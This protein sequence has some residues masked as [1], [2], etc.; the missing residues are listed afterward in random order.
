[1]DPIVLRFCILT[2][3]NQMAVR[4]LFISKASVHMLDMRD[5]MKPYWF[6]N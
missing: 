6:M 3:E 1:M 4:I 5:F 2:L